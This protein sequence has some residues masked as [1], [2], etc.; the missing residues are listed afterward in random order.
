MMATKGMEGSELAKSLLNDKTGEDA[1]MAYFFA[2]Y[3]AMSQSASKASGQSDKSEP[4]F[5]QLRYILADHQRKPIPGSTHKADG[6]F[7]YPKRVHHGIPRVHMF[8]EAK[9]ASTP[10]KIP[11][12]TMDQLFDYV[13]AVWTGQPTRTFVPILYLHGEL[14]TLFVFTRGPWYRIELGSIC[15]T[16]VN[17]HLPEIDFVRETLLRL[18]FVITL[19]SDRFGHFCDV[20]TRLQSISF[21]R[22]SANNKLVKA[23]L[24]DSKDSN[25]LS[26]EM[27]IPRMANPRSRL[28]YLFDTMYQSKKAVLKLSWTPVRRLP[29]GAI[30]EY[31]RRAG[32]GGVPEVY[33]SGLIEDNFFGY[34][35]EYIVLEHCGQSIG[36]HV[37][38]S[39]RR[40]VPESE[41]HK[42]VG[43]FVSQVSSCL[44]QARIHGVL[45]RD[46]SDGNIAVSNGQAKVIDWGYA[47]IIEASPSEA[48]GASPSVIDEIA[49]QWGFEKKEVLDN[50]ISWDGMTGTVVFMSISVLLGM[51]KRGLSDDIESLF[52]V[53]IRA[54]AKSDDCSGFRHYDNNNLALA[55]TGILGCANKY[56]E[57][58]N[59]SGDVGVLKQMLDAMH[60][61]LFFSGDRYIGHDLVSNDCY[62]RLPSLDMAARFMDEKTVHALRLLSPS[63]LRK[64]CT[65]SKR[66]RKTST[67][68]SE[69][70]QFA[71]K[72]LRE[73]NPPNA[74]ASRQ[75]QTRSRTRRRN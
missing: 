28:A 21:G 63:G 31:L 34:R 38:D 32:I 8:V 69:R 27:R 70:A 50:E 47:K 7:Y 5:P 4:K 16:S 45:H 71:R 60:R 1:L 17:P 14:L 9:V 67:S 56:L 19:P 11:D 48:Q 10:G 35:L 29:E 58:F 52:Y 15:Y 64:P 62:E 65:G 36:S 44:V 40:R 43:H 59:I 68:S 54:F 3:E 23:S 37:K 18:W 24:V 13:N 26:L 57:F 51:T 49:R 42:Q 46:I 73:I 20:D 30:Y 72:P 25:K 22:S 41:I 6:V 12:E 75:I 61:Y 53:I 74:T 33:D 66:K 55:R 39:R 2:L